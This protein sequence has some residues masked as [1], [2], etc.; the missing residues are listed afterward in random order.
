MRVIETEECVIRRIF[1]EVMGK[2]VKTTNVDDLAPKG[3][4]ETPW[5]P[6]EIAD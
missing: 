4:I 1:S 5:G 3:E 6:D 2:E